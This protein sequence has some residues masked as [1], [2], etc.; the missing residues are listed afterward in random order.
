MTVL[1]P[2]APAAPI[3][4]TKPLKLSEAMRLG[5]MV[6]T[7]TN[8]WGEV[9]EDGNVYACALSAAWYALTGHRQWSAHGSE[10]V[11]ALSRVLVADPINGNPTSLTTAIISLNDS[12]GW[13]RQKIA[14]WLEGMGL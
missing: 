9:D 11:D 8:D 4:T 7:Q 1:A 10:L 13:S 5:S 2:E 6:T 12:H 3:E 14:D